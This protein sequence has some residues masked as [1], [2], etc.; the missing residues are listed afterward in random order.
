MKMNEYVDQW[1]HG[2][3][4]EC[5]EKGINGKEWMHHRLEGNFACTSEE[6]PI[7]RADYVQ[8]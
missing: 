1:M 6:C 8:N 5:A 2:Y 7:I 3:V 4:Y